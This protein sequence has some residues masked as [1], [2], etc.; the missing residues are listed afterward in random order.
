MKKKKGG[1]DISSSPRAAFPI[2]NIHA[3]SSCLDSVIT[4]EIYSELPKPSPSIVSL[5]A[6]I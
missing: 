4:S 3:T 6:N 2:I 5:V 1:D